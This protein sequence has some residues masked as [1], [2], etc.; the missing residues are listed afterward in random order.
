[1]LIVENRKW[2]I[3]LL[4]TKSF[5]L[6]GGGVWKKGSL[7][8]QTSVRRAINDRRSWLSGES[9]LRRMEEIHLSQTLW[10]S[11]EL[12]SSTQIHSLGIQPLLWKQLVVAPF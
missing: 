7:G 2:T 4:S 5:T 10:A 11:N 6:E 9:R 3:P 12:F 1:M 8:G